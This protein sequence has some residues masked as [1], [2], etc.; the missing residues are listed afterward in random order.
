MMAAI[1]RRPKSHPM[2]EADLYVLRSSDGRSII[3]CMAPEL[4]AALFYVL[5]RACGLDSDVMA[6]GEARHE[7]G[8]EVN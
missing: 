1:K 3:W 8:I 7:A 6:L 4:E 2:D 5:D